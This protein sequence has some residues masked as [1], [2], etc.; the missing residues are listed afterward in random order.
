MVRMSE[1]AGPVAAQRTK[2]P[3]AV[4]LVLRGGLTL[5][6]RFAMLPSLHDG[7]RRSHSAR[8]PQR[9]RRPADPEV[10]GRRRTSRVRDRPV[11][12]RLVWT[13]PRTRRELALHRPAAA[14]VEWL[15]D[16]YLGRFREQP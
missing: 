4:P 12:P 6:A 15:G 2:A 11:H 9:Q 8:T 10:A 14:P 7:I 1:T 5:S 16:R 13:G 3:R